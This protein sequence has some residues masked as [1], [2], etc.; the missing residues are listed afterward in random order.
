MNVTVPTGL[1]VLIDNSFAFKGKR[2]VFK[3]QVISF[4]TSQFFGL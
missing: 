1:L 4:K 3:R 2:I